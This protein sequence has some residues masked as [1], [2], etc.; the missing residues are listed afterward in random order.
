MKLSMLD[1]VIAEDG[2]DLADQLDQFEADGFPNE[3]AYQRFSR[4]ILING[5]MRTVTLSME[6]TAKPTLRQR[7]RHA[8]MA[9]GI[10]T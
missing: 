3:Y 5:K 7:Q 10:L 1:D 6:M 4:D 9:A 2:K 8:L